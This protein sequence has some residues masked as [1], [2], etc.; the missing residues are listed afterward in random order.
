MVMFT[1]LTPEDAAVALPVP[2]LTA[3]RTMVLLRCTRSWTHAGR[4]GNMLIIRGVNVVPR[5]ESV[6]TQVPGSGLHL[7]LTRTIPFP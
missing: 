7:L 2:G 5:G 3:L 4:R 1:H 6:I